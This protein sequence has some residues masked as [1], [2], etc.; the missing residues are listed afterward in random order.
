VSRSPWGERCPAAAFPR[1]NRPV[2]EYVDRPEEPAR[3]VIW[4]AFNILRCH[5]KN[6]Y[7]N[8]IESVNKILV[9]PPVDELSKQ[10]NRTAAAPHINEQ[11][12]T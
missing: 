5:L 12:P 7:M 8:Y 3:P 4:K 11:E 1:P 6:Q 10:I 9:E 2:Y